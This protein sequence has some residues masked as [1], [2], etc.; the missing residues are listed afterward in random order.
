LANTLNETHAG[1]QYGS[2]AEQTQ[3][4][5]QQVHQQH[6]YDDLDV[7]SQSGNSSH[8]SA[9]SPAHLQRHSL[10]NP[11]DQHHQQ[12]QQQQ[13]QPHSAL[14]I[15][16]ARELFDAQQHQQNVALGNVIGARGE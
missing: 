16:M 12:Q 5:A 13:Q 14:S 1:Q 6:I 4:Q 2:L 7:V 8:Q 10:V 9:G 11:L 15:M 3:L